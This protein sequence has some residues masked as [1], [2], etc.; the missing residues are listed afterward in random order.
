M[1]I[2]IKKIIVI[3]LFAVIIPVLYHSGIEIFVPKV[4]YS[5]YINKTIALNED[6][7]Y[8]NYE[9]NETL[10]H[11]VEER[12]VFEAERYKKSEE[13]RSASDSSRRKRVYTGFIVSSICLV[14]SLY[15]NSK[16]EIFAIGLQAGSLTNL[17]IT[18]EIMDYIEFSVPL[19][20]FFSVIIF[21]IALL[22][23]RQIPDKTRQDNS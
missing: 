18:N 8:Y 20:S 23:L 6:G 4:K 2:I 7:N 1:D 5:D 22:I 16:N 15:I 17:V 21:T 3:I 11:T 10:T 12:R 9:T 13:Y 14:M 19:I